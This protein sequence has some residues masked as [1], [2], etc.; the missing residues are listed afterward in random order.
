MFVT[1]YIYITNSS[2]SIYHLWYSYIPF[3]RSGLIIMIFIK[4]IFYAAKLDQQ[5]SGR[6]GGREANHRQDRLLTIGPHCSSHFKLEH[7]ETLIET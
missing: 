3:I 7:P 5:E 2:L 1:I 6:E 4:N